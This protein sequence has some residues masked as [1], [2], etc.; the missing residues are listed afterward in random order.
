MTSCIWVWVL[1]GWGE[2][3]TN[4]HHC[5]AGSHCDEPPYDGDSYGEM[6]VTTCRPD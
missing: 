2:P 5:P 1:T 3:P 6:A 4:P